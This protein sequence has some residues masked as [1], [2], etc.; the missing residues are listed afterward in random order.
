MTF[1]KGQLLLKN[2]V[3]FMDMAHEQSRLEQGYCRRLAG[4]CNLSRKRINDDVSA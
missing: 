4:S 2:L 3:V 1:M